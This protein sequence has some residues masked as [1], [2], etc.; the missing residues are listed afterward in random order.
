MLWP[1][2]AYPATAPCAQNDEASTSFG[3]PVEIAVL[4]NDIEATANTETHLEKTEQ[5]RGGTFSANTA[6][7]IVIFQPDPGFTGTASAHYYA[8]DSWGIRTRGLIE[9]E[10]QVE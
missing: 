6:T 8:Y 5:A 9:V 7:G 4:D 1:V 3:E 2:V 10:V